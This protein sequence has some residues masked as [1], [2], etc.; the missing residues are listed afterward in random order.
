VAALLVVLE[1]ATKA[2]LVEMVWPLRTL[3]PKVVAVEVLP[4]LDKRAQAEHPAKVGM[5]SLPALLDLQSHGPA[6]E[7]LE[8]FILLLL[9]LQAVQAAEGEDAIAIMLQ[10][11]EQL[12][13]AAVVVVER[14]ALAVQEL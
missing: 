1:L 6:V 8:R 7:V 10:T 11:Q 2:V 9:T 5:V 12:T 3:R 4:T 13:P 14:T